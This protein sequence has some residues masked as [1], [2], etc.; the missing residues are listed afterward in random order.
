MH[1]IDT[2]SKKRTLIDICMEES[3]GLGVDCIIDDGG[4]WLFSFVHDCFLIFLPYPFLFFLIYFVSLLLLS[5]HFPHSCCTYLIDSFLSSTV[6]PKSY[7]M[8]S[9]PLSLLTMVI[10]FFVVIMYLHLPP[11]C[12]GHSIV[13]LPL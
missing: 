3:G 9:F 1:V 11:I 7:Y 13:S 10:T 2:R 8:F 6:T 12:C 4:K 5:L